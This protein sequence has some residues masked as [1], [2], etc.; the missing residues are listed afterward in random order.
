MGRWEDGKMGRWEDGKMRI[1]ETQR[2]PS[3]AEG[4][5]SNKLA[6]QYKFELDVTTFTD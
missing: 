6:A 3:V 2:S 4:W 1:W 5:P